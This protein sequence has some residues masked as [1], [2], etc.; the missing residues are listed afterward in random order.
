MR[1]GIAFPALG[2]LKPW[3]AMFVLVGLAGLVPTLL[4]ALTVREPVRH[5]LADASK[6][7]A[8]AAD[9][10]RFIGQ[11]RVT[12]LCHHF[13]IAFT[14]MTAYGFGNWMPT[15]FMRVHGW[16]P[17]RFAVIY[18]SIALVLGVL[19][20]LA[21][22]WLTTW[23]ND[24]GVR[25]ASWRIALAGSIGCS[26]CGAIAPLM[27]TPELSLAVYVLAGLCASPPAVLAM[28]AISEFVPNEMRGVITGIYFMIIGIIA[29]GLGPLAVGL[30]TDYLFVDRAAIGRSLSL[31]SLLTG[32][33]AAALLFVGLRS[34]RE[35]LDRATW[36]RE[37]TSAMQ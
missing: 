8:S 7:N 15:F 22:G 24:R 33:P 18:G 29:T 5:E 12:L 20:P 26:S 4:F 31:V 23:F 9:I 14:V 19:A 2:H 10:R 13:G 1:G 11:N 21:A 36:T 6:R 30:A 3:Q 16:P 28:I 32:I 17:Q 27:P 34:F 37:S 25:D 35:S